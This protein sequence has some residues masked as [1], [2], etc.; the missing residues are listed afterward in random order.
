MQGGG[1]RMKYT[2]KG[3]SSIVVAVVAL[4]IVGFSF[5]SSLARRIGVVEP[6]VR[7]ERA[8]GEDT[9][10]AATL[11][12]MQAVRQVMDGEVFTTADRLREACQLAS[13]GGLLA[14]LERRATAAALL[15]KLGNSLPPGVAQT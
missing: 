15:S 10:R 4:I 13:V 1:S 5:V 8:A 11:T 12:R 14:V 2:A 7:I 9:A 6:R 3:R